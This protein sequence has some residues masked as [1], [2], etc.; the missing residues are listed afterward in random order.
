VLAFIVS[1]VGFGTGSPVDPAAADDPARHHGAAFREAYRSAY[2]AVLERLAV[3]HR[4]CDGEPRRPWEAPPA[5]D[6]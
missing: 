4:W 6:E 3:A 1:M 5:T 2:R